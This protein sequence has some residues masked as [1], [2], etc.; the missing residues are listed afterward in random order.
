MNNIAKLKEM[1]SSGSC[2]TYKILNSLVAPRDS[3][4]LQPGLEYIY[5]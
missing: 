4:Y 3:S 2:I 5:S 1:P